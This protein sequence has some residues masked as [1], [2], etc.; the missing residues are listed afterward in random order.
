M[1]LKLIHYLRPSL[2]FVDVWHGVSFM[3][4]TP[5][6]FK[7]MRFYSAYFVSSEYY[8][9]VYAKYRGFEENKIIATGMAKHDVLYHAAENSDNIKKE[10]NI[11][12]FSKIILFAPTWWGG[13]NGNIE[14]EQPFDL[15]T[16]G[17]LNDFNEICKSNNFLTIF[18]LHQNS[19]LKVKDNIYSN[20]LLLPQTKY[21]DTYGLLT[22]VD[23]L[24][25]DW[26]SIAPDFTALKR[27]I[28]YI[29]NP[30]PIN[31]YK[32]GLSLPL[33]RGG[34][35]VDNVESF[36]LEIVKLLKYKEYQIPESQNKLN[37]DVFGNKYDGD[38]T[39][40]CCEEITKLI[41]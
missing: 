2:P 12:K 15:E 38:C 3:D 40:R 30:A 6:I 5:E 18:R 11:N 28:I 27:P 36:F 37:N 22:C 31:F 39:N 32:S 23:L 20:I 9:G 19:S 26:S 17:F 4:Y 7:D 33:Q 24:I 29:D 34:V 13:K 35:I 10:L 1:S 8:K 14:N 25:T 21:P 16:Y 41:S